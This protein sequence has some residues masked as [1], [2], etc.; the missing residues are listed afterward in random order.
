MS[1]CILCFFFSIPPLHLFLPR[2]DTTCLQLHFCMPSEG[3]H[4]N[5]PP[6]TQFI[7]TATIKFLSVA[8]NRF[9][10]L[11]VTTTFTLCFD[12]CY[13]YDLHFFSADSVILVLSFLSVVLHFLVV[14]AFLVMTSVSPIFVSAQGRPVNIF[15]CCTITT[16]RCS[17]LLITSF[18][19]FDVFVVRMNTIFFSLLPSPPSHMSVD[20]HWLFNIT[21]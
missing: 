4:C 3:R 14:N 21:F 12:V 17:V 19:L 18:I 1:A 9:F 16:Y 6:I 7:V 15:M 20:G 8:C 2:D 10:S 13:C 5:I 11:L